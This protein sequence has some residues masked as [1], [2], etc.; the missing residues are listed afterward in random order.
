M[1]MEGDQNITWHE[2]VPYIPP[3]VAFPWGLAGPVTVSRSTQRCRGA[4]FSRSQDFE[5]GFADIAESPAYGDT[6]SIVR[7]SRLIVNSI[8]WQS[9]NLSPVD[10]TVIRGVEGHIAP[11]C[12]ADP[13]DFDGSAAVASSC[14][15]LICV[16]LTSLA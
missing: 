8:T 5:C 2:T 11:E 4:H 3:A 16:L 1:T 13:F 14:V 7:K 10:S 12:N 9:T 6:A 15:P